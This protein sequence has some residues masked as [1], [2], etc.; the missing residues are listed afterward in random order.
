[1]EETLYTPQL[2]PYCKPNRTIATKLVRDFCRLK[3]EP[4][5]YIQNEIQTILRDDR[6]LGIVR[7][8]TDYI[9]TGMAK[10][11]ELTVMIA[12]ARQWMEQYH[13]TKI[14]LA[15]EDERIFD[16]FNEAFPNQILVNKRTYY[17]KA[18]TDQ[19]VKW[20]GQVHFNRENDDYYKGLEYLSSIY[21]LSKCQA[22]L[23]GYC[24]AGN[25]AM[26]LNGGKYEKIKVYDLG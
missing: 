19:N 15:T 11:P 16:K 23:A 25:M 4:A 12:E 9:G 21:I 3:P 18:M 24:G 2:I 6:V 17:D 26:L 20:I 14:Y 8:G 22:L 5:A 7:R 10:Q 1:M 13:Y